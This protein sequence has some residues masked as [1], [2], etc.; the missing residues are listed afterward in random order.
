MLYFRPLIAMEEFDSIE[1]LN[2]D[3]N[4]QFKIID[5]LKEKL[6]LRKQNLLIISVSILHIHKYNNINVQSS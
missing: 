2:N 3:I 5:S 4:L 6:M 1:L